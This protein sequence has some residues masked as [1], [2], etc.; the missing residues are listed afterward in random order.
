MCPPHVIAGGLHMQ[1]FACFASDSSAPYRY[2]CQADIFWR[3]FTAVVGRGKSRAVSRA[4]STKPCSTLEEIREI[5]CHPRLDE[6][7]T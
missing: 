2:T 1:I 4:S 3:S 7:E 5:V 6:G